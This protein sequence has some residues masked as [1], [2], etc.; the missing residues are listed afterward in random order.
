M[1]SGLRYHQAMNRCPLTL[2]DGA[3]I[4]L[5]GSMLGLGLLMAAGSDDAFAHHAL[6]RE[7]QIAWEPHLHRVDD[8]L[9][10]N[11]LAGA[12]M[13]WREAYAAALKSRHWEGMVASG[14]AYRRIG[15]R[16]NFGKVSDA[17]AREAYLI[18]LFRARSEGSL[19]GVLRAAERFAD[20]GDHAVVEQCL[21]VARSVA[22]RSKDPRAEERVRSFAERWGAR[23]RGA[24]QRRFMP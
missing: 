9:A 19:E 1:V 15:E 22:A 20:L 16:A 10:R 21:G 6:G 7:A 13:L 2:P 11:D 17:K 14:D 5:I 12:E 3:L 8:A 23:T 4:S 18:A 24:D